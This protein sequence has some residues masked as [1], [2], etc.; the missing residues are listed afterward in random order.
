MRLSAGRAISSIPQN[1]NDRLALAQR[2]NYIDVDKLNEKVEWAR[3]V[4]RPLFE[5]L[6]A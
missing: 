1:E 5:Q 2:C 6:I 3:S 4:S